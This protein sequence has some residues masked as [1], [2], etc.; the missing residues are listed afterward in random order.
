MAKKI[1]NDNNDQL[2]SEFKA[3]V[4]DTEQ[5]L[6]HS[7]ELTGDKAEELRGQINSSLQRARKALSSTE[8]ALLERGKEAINSSEE[9]V[10]EHPLQ[11]LAIGAGVGFL[12]GLLV[13]KR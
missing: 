5:L 13:S 11:S 6:Q 9:Y 10:R 3:L 1:S 4:S 12:L 2:L 7:V 8:Y